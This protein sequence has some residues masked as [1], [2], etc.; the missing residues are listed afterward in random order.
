MMATGIS[1]GS[2]QFPPSPP[3][4]RGRMMKSLLIFVHLTGNMDSGI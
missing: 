2:S 3:T 4:R 1:T